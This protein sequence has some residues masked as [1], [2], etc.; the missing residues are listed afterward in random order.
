M[1]PLGTGAIRTLTVPRPMKTR[2][3]VISNWVG[4]GARDKTTSTRVELNN[5]AIKN[6]P[7]TDAVWNVL[8][9]K[10][11]AHTH[12]VSNVL[13]QKVF[14]WHTHNPKRVGSSD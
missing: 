6:V 8:T 9:P 10:N 14:P 7:H 3:G 5:L 1:E 11:A 13:I 2:R 4:V 12:A